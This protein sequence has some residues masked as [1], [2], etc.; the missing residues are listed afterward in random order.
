MA[1]YYMKMEFD[2]PEA[3]EK[4]QEVQ[5]YFY[6]G[7]RA[8]DWWQDHR[9][10]TPVSFWRAFKSQFPLVYEYLLS[11]VRMVHKDYTCLSVLYKDCNN[12][13]SGKLDIGNKHDVEEMHVVDNAIQYSAEVW[14]CTDWQ[15]L[16][17]FIEEKFGATR[18]KW[19]SDEHTSVSEL[20]M[21]HL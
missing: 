18:V 12:S 1:V 8:Y 20:I 4:L 17:R 16:A 14:H 2:S 9:H 11:I 21:E 5:D 3:Q 15:H 6:E 19:T 13:L 10:T 7:V